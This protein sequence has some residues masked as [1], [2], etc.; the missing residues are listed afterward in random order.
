MGSPYETQACDV[1][2]PLA[3][4]TSIPG[5]SGAM[6]RLITGA[7]VL[8]EIPASWK[9]NFV[10]LKV[11]G[12]CQIAF[13]DSTLSLVYD[14][15]SGL[16]GAV[17]AADVNT[18]WPYAADEKDSFRVPKHKTITHFAVV[19]PGSPSGGFWLRVSNNII[20]ED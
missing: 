4:N 8:Y 18:G 11:T 12:A 17:L 19:G 20:V 1:S 13:G 7:S 14:E 10:D 15:R 3:L 6:S 2:P 16:S 5:P 9:G